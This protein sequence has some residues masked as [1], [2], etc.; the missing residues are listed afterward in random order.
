MSTSLEKLPRAQCDTCHGPEEATA[1]C[2]ECMGLF[3]TQC[4]VFN[5]STAEIPVP[6]VYCFKCDGIVGAV[7]HRRRMGRART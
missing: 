7:E 3:C 4:V 2:N 1:V 6:R 5:P